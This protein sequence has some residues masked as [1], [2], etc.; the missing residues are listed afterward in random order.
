STRCSHRSGCAVSGP[1]S[2]S[3]SRTRRRSDTCSALRCPI[4]ARSARRAVSRCGASRKNR[5]DTRMAR[6]DTGIAD[7]SADTSPQLYARVGGVLYLA[8]IAAGINGE[9]F[10]RGS[11]VVSGDAAAT[12]R[13]LVGSSVL[14]RAGIAGDLVMHLCDVGLM[15]VFYVLL[16]PVSRNLALLAVLF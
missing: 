1:A 2:R 9:L 7:A 13:N 11:I 10:V 5:A 3:L 12:A 14:W 6:P 4:A 15:L 16:K 8:I